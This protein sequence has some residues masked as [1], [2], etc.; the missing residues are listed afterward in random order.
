MN[1]V[2]LKRPT[3]LVTRCGATM[4]SVPYATSSEAEV[5]WMKK[6][7][8]P[9]LSTMH[10]IEMDLNKLAKFCRCVQSFKPLRRVYGG[11]AVNSNI[12]RN[13]FVA[14]LANCWQFDLIMPTG[15]VRGHLGCFEAF[16]AFGDR[17][18]GMV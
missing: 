5:A 18:F 9:P 4:R 3:L 1:W 15:K 10:S 8:L 12:R 17:H 13:D 7:F 16:W 11:V 6:R 2:R 14:I